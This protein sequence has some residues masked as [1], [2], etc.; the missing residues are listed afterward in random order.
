MFCLTCF[1]C[2]KPGHGQGIRGQWIPFFK[3]RKSS[4]RNRR[5][6]QTC[7]NARIKITQ[8]LKPGLSLS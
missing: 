5:S 7:V 6:Y 2:N 3:R 1:G 8:I 4:L